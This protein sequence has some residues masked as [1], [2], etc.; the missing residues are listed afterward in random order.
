[1]AVRS[2]TLLLSLAAFAVAP[3]PAPDPPDGLPPWGAALFEKFNAMESNIQAQSQ[4]SVA[5]SALLAE[6]RL[7]ILEN[8]ARIL[9]LEAA[10]TQQGQGAPSPPLTSRSRKQ[11]PATSCDSSLAAARTQGVMD[12]CCPSAGQGHRRLQAECALPDTCGTVQC[13]DSFIPFYEDCTALVGSNAEY[14]AF[15][16]NC[17]ELQAQSAQ[18]LLQPVTVQMFKVH[19]ATNVT[20]APV[21]APPAASSGPGGSASAAVQEY[22]AVCRSASINDCIP[23]CNATHHGY[24]LLATVDGT[25]TKF[26]CNIAHGL[27]SWVGAAS[28]GGYLGADF[29]SFFSAVISGA[30]GLCEQRLPKL[31]PLSACGYTKLSQFTQTKSARQSSLC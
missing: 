15:F 14:Q 8:S 29:A 28:E 20:A 25:D 6:Q 19:I 30:A 24:E 23:T 5:N 13:A 3:S 31:Y 1:M 9:E 7:Q 10:L 26:S 4:A 16:A 22:H 11:T 2:L 27:F 18:M 17:Q 21:P 12:A